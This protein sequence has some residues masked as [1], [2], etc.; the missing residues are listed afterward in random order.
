MAFFTD[1]DR[2][3]GAAAWAR[4]HAQF[5]NKPRFR[6]LVE[7]ML[8]PLGRLRVTAQQ[9]TLLRG[10]DT[11]Q[12][13]QLDGVGDIL[14]L[15]RVVGG[16]ITFGFFGFASQPAGRNFGVARMRRDGEPWSASATLPDEDYRRLLRAKIIL[17]NG[18]GT[19]HDIAEATKIL[20]N[21]PY[22]Y[23]QDKATAGVVTLYIGYLPEVGD[24]LWSIFSGML[25]K[26]A[27]IR[28][29]PSYWLSTFHPLPP[30]LGGPTPIALDF[31]RG[32]GVQDQVA[33]SSRKLHS[34][35]TGPCMRVRRS[36][37]NAEQDIGFTSNALNESALTT[38]CGS[39]DGFVVRWYNQ[40]LAAGLGDASQGTLALQPQIVLAGAV[41]KRSGIPA[42]SLT[43]GRHLLL[44]GY[45][46]KPDCFLAAAYE[47]TTQHGVI[48]ANTES[49]TNGETALWASGLASFGVRPTKR[50]ASNAAKTLVAWKA[51]AGPQTSR[52]NGVDQ[53]AAATTRGAQNIGLALGARPDGSDICNG[54]I[55]AFL[56]GDSAL[57]AAQ[58]AEIED[59]FSTG[60]SFTL[61]TATKQYPLDYAAVYSL[62]PT[63]AISTRK[64]KAA[65]PTNALR[66]RR[67]SDNAEQDVAWSGDW[68]DTAAAAAFVGAGGGSIPTWY[69]QEGANFTQSTADRQ[70]ILYAGGALQTMGGAPA[71]R[72]NGLTVTASGSAGTWTQS[73]MPWLSMVPADPDDAPNSGIW[74]LSLPPSGTSGGPSLAMDTGGAGFWVRAGVT[75]AVVTPNAGDPTSASVLT[76][77]RTATEV[78]LRQGGR[79]IAAAPLSSGALVAP[80]GGITLG[81]FANNTAT[82]GF[83]G[84]IPEAIVFKDATVSETVRKHLEASARDAFGLE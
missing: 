2:E 9:M 47:G 43:S 33:L 26:G 45:Q 52:I 10:V 6:A 13:A 27:G 7:S 8:P 5:Q 48:A 35:Y 19:Q 29:E 67:S 50:F 70:P 59:Y 3:E 46:T 62:T 71:A 78:S 23:A 60:L 77:R 81:K 15:P 34:Q 80:T 36:S 39:G 73:A 68:L 11:A 24:P 25:P 57:T 12:G 76:V 79:K 32:A 66:V 63:L 74:L 28:V 14:G 21:V 18:R 84:L 72:F 4:V 16:L 69:A 65:A 75:P 20:F 30:A 42:V 38:F 55:V 54:K 51:A 53:G 41:I 83:Q 82:D 40:G 58:A 49:E 17:N 31:A 64:L 1:E 44:T 37:D 61:G 22:A 56:V